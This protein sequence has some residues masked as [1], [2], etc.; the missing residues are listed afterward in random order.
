MAPASALTGEHGLRLWCLSLRILIPPPPR[1][2][3]FRGR[4]YRQ[5]FSKQNLSETVT[6]TFC[7]FD[8]NPKDPT[9]SLDDGKFNGIHTA[10]Q[11]KGGKKGNPP[12]HGF[13][14]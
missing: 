7:S 4:F 10:G 8:Y 6:P 5:F 11:G 14:N 2:V 3:P 9:S 13:Y 12:T 1:R